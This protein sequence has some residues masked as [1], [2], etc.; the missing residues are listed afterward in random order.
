MFARV[1]KYLIDNVYAQPK[2]SIYPSVHLTALENDEVTAIRAAFGTCPLDDSCRH[3]LNRPV[4]NMHKIV[5]FI[6]GLEK[7]D[8]GDTADLIRTISTGKWCDTYAEV[9]RN[10]GKATPILTAIKE[11]SDVKGLVEYANVE[12]TSS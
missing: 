9:F 1:V 4:D 5:D 10:W 3:F 7:V 11:R 2:E 6:K 8:V 12:G